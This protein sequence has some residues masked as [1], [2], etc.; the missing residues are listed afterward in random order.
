MLKK[1]LR[2][3]VVA[4][5]ALGLLG[6]GMSPAEATTVATVTFVGAATTGNLGYPCVTANVGPPPTVTTTCVT[7]GPPPTTTLPTT[8]TS[9]GKL[10]LPNVTVSGPSTGFRFAS[11]A[12]VGLKVDLLKAKDGPAPATAYGPLCQIRAAGTVTGYCG[13]SSATGTG[14]IE[15]FP[16]AKKVSFTFTFT[17]VGGTLFVRGNSSKGTI[18]A[19]VQ[20][21]PNPTEGSCLAGNQTGFAIVGTATIAQPTVPPT[22]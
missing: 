22:V 5:A 10:G 18:V 7:V 15:F 20:A 19:V 17:G 8:S 21:V 11:T 3:G 13:L 1:L 16:L 14:E 6:S 2:V 12:C 4:G 9:P